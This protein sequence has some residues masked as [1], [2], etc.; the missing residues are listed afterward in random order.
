LLCKQAFL[1][2]LIVTPEKGSAAMRALWDRCIELFLRLLRLRIRLNIEYADPTHTHRGTGKSSTAGWS[3]YDLPSAENIRDR[4]FR[5]MTGGKADVM[6]CFEVIGLESLRCRFDTHWEMIEDKVHQVVQLII[7]KHLSQ[8]DI[9]IP[10]SKMHYGILFSNTSRKAA[11]KKATEIRQEILDTFLKDTTFKAD[12]DIQMGP[13]YYVAKVA[14][15]KLKLHAK[16]VRAEGQAAASSALH[17]RAHV[18]EASTCAVA[19][20]K[21]Y[22]RPPLLLDENGHGILSRNIEYRYRAIY[23]QGSGTISALRYMYYLSTSAGGE[24]YEYDVLPEE[25]DED[26]YLRLDIEMLNVIADRLRNKTH[27]EQ[28]KKIR[29]KLICPVNYKTLS[30]AQTRDAYARHLRLLAKNT[31][32]KH[33]GFEILFMPR[34]LYGPALRDPLSTLRRFSSYVVVR[35]AEIDAFPEESYRE[36]GAIGVSVFCAS[37][38]RLPSMAAHAKFQR[39]VRA[40]NKYKLRSYAFGLDTEALCIDAENAGFSCLCGDG[41]LKKH[42]V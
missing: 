24:L 13:A 14:A 17:Y 12:V 4:F 28:T 29:P 31:S 16:E 42:P 20:S 25:A 15:R 22:T 9:F 1:D 33:L 41:V 35:C 5:H 27:I 36:A 37:L 30:N 3:V 7:A 23:D 6:T 19:E 40:A 26:M 32:F 10:I 21:P 2:G 18:T 34:A 8:E 39:F 11:Q 38:S